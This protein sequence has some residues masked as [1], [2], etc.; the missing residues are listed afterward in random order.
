MFCVIAL[1]LIQMVGQFLVIILMAGGTTFTRL[2]NYYTYSGY[3]VNY[4]AYLIEEDFSNE[5]YEVQS[6]FL[7]S[8]FMYIFTV[9]AFNIGAPWKRPF[10]TNPFFMLVLAFIFTY[11]VLICVVYKARISKFHLQRLHM[12]WNVMVLGLGLAFGVFMYAL[13]KFLMEPLFN[14]LRRRHP[15][16]SWL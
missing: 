3:D 12:G 8:N 13:Q 1:F 4:A 14:W 7:F 16:I 2:L 9:L 6:L 15:K 11:S 5:T 10:F